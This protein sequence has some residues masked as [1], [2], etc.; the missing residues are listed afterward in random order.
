MTNSK[1]ELTPSAIGAEFFRTLVS[2]DQL[3]AVVQIQILFDQFLGYTKTT[4]F[5]DLEPHQRD[6]HAKCVRAHLENLVLL[7]QY[8]QL[9]DRNE[10]F[11]MRIA[12]EQYQKSAIFETYTSLGKETAKNVFAH[13]VHPE[14]LEVEE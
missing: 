2:D 7:H 9:P 6:L 8:Q 4:F 14:K 10:L 5:E 12:W 1:V 11:H 13:A 3:P